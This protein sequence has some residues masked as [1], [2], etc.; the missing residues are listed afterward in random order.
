MRR[1]LQVAVPVLI[2]GVT[3]AFALTGRWPWPRLR[4]APP[5]LVTQAWAETADTLRRG[6]TVSDLFARNNVSGLAL[7][8]LTTARLLDPRRLR[9]GMIFSF[10][11][12]LED[13]TPSS[14][15]FRAGP[16]A[17]VE[18]V[19]D[20]ARQWTAASLPITWVADTV[21]LEGDIDASLYVALDDEVPDSVF[22]PGERIRLAWDLADTYMW[23]V[24]FTRDIREGD[25]FQVLA[26][27][28]VSEEGE[29]RFS[30]I[31]AADLRISGKDQPAFGF[32]DSAGKSSFYDE[33]GNWLRRAFLRAPVRFRR[34]SS[35]FSRA[36]KHP[37]LNIVR[38]HQGTDYAADAGT[39]VMAA[40]NGTVVRAGWAGGYGNLIEIRHAN[41]ISTRYGHLRAFAR[42][43]RSG[44]RV[45][46]GQVIGYVGMTGLAN[47]PHLH[48]EFRVN[49]V[50][51]DSRR[52]DLGSGEPVPARERA[53]F[54]SVKAVLSGL[55]YP[56]ARRPGGPADGSIAIGR[57]PEDATSGTR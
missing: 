47:A 27:R 23:Q 48:Y 33:N 50:A 37:I 42:G 15:L 49:G 51:R 1:F 52:V 43:I 6:E 14:V 13:S 36:R 8:A 26:E 54:D 2:L 5:I 31:L 55:L 41:G 57:P 30:R 28:L 53:A 9:P 56:V 22:D 39:E 16:E 35:G 4:E 21:R 29:V 45:N 10:R 12:A 7:E 24:D 19:L 34:I 3:A 25:H 44:V 17:R 46:Q 38:A 18:V 40:G 32:Q 20:T 11:R